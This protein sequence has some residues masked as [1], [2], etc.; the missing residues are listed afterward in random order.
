MEIIKWD[1]ETQKLLGLYLLSTGILEM[2]LAELR[3][4]TSKEEKH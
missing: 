3:A 1:I 2:R 4:D